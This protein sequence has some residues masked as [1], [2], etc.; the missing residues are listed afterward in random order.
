MG[1]LNFHLTLPA[2]TKWDED[3]KVFVS[4]TPVFGIYSQGTS[5]EEAMEALKSAI[6][7]Y[8]KVAYEENIL[9]K[10]LR[11]HGFTLVSKPEAAEAQIGLPDMGSFT[12]LFEVP[13]VLPLTSPQPA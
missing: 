1:K 7:L 11:R 12:N 13:A 10:T 5:E 6:C 8:L 2:A 9:D 4:Y 3:A